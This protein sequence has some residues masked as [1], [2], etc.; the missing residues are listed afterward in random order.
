MKF[1][2]NATEERS[3]PVLPAG[4]YEFDVEKVEYVRSKSGF[5]NWKL[6]LAFENR[7][8]IHVKVF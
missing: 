7:E 6:T 8:G 2:P 5:M 3:Y 1:D 4:E